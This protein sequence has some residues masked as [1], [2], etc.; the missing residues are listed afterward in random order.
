MS[1]KLSSAQKRDFKARAAKLEPAV[2]V[3]HAGVSPGFLQ[4]LETAL[5][6]HELVKVKF[7]DH[8]EEKKTLAP[9]IA[10]QTRSELVQRVGNVAVYYR[11]KPEPAED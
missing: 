11:R 4:S 10:E 5:G 8:K 3:G 1:S 6:Q 2:K 7:T 9:L